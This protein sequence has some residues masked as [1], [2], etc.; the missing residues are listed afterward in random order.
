MSAKTSVL[1]NCTRLVLWLKTWV[2]N[3]WVWTRTGSDPGTNSRLKRRP[4]QTQSGEQERSHVF[5]A[6][7]EL[8]VS[9]GSLRKS[10]QDQKGRGC[11][12]ATTKYLDIKISTDLLQIFTFHAK[13]C[14]ALL[15]TLVMWACWHC[16]DMLT[17]Q[18]N[19]FWTCLCKQLVKENYLFLYTSSLLT[20]IRSIIFFAVLCTAELKI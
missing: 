3:Q 9:K 2:G 13:V 7:R 15:D 18:L 6:P 5:E 11:S 16:F 8:K 4:F 12:N 20:W 1:T 10:W 17:P 19:C 14:S